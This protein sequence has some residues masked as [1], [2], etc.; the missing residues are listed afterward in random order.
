MKDMTIGRL[1]ENE[2]LAMTCETPR[3]TMAWEVND[4]NIGHEIKACN[5]SENIWCLCC[6]RPETS[7]NQWQPWL[8][9][10]KPHKFKFIKKKWVRHIDK[11]LVCTFE[12]GHDKGSGGTWFFTKFLHTT[13]FSLKHYS[14]KI[15]ADTR[16]KQTY[17][18]RLKKKTA[19]PVALWL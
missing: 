14:W 3:K 16:Y 17:K 12:I 13:Q 10:F 11:Y 2:R 7:N 18:H 5:V 8:D 15:G 4:L 1:R 6:L 9:S 19:Q